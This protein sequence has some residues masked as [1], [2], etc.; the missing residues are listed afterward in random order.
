MSKIM[1]YSGEDVFV[2][3]L[4]HRGQVVNV[5]NEYIEAV[6]KAV[7]EV[8]GDENSTYIDSFDHIVY[9]EGDKGMIAISIEKLY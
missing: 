4:Y 6:T 9:V 2:Y 3:V 7:E 1:T 5:Y 8:T